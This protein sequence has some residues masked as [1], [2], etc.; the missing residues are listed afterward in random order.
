[1]LLLSLFSFESRLP[2]ALF[3]LSPEPHPLSL[4]LLSVESIP[5]PLFDSLFSDSIF[6]SLFSSFFSRVSFLSSGVSS[7]FSSGSISIL[8]STS[9][10]SGSCIS[11]VGVLV[12]ISFTFSSSFSGKGIIVSFFGSFSISSSDCS[13][14]GD[15]FINTLGIKDIFILDLSLSVGSG[16]NS[17][18]SSC[19]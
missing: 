6:I 8:F 19:F 12:C 9:F 11:P 14:F 13:F 15:L 1:M 5:Q 3:E 4:F 10:T 2:Q 17:F 18:F 7:F 16:V